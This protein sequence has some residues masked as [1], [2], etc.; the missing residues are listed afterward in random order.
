MLIRID[1]YLTK[2]FKNHFI[3]INLKCLQNLRESSRITLDLSNE[4]GLNK[5]LN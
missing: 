3:L 1:F 5:R 4:L 2:K